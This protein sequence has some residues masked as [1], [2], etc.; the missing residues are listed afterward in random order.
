[1]TIRRRL[2]LILVGLVLMALPPSAKAQSGSW[3]YVWHTHPPSGSPGDGWAPVEVILTPSGCSGCD[4]GGSWAP[5][6]AQGLMERPADRVTVGH[7]A[8]GDR[9]PAWDP[10]DVCPPGTDLAGELTAGTWYHNAN[11]DIECVTGGC[12]YDYAHMTAYCE[13]HCHWGGMLNDGWVFIEDDDCCPSGTC[14]PPDP[15]ACPPE[16]WRYSDISAG[17]WRTAPSFPVVIGQDPSNLGVDLLFDLTLPPAT[18]TW[19]EEVVECQPTPEPLPGETPEPP[20][21]VTSCEEHQLSVRDT[22]NGAEATL[23]LQEASRRWIEN[24]LALRYPHAAVRQPH[25][26]DSA[27]LHAC[28]YA[29]NTH[30][31]T[32]LVHL[33]PE[34]PGYYDLSAG[35]TADLGGGRSFSFSGA[36]VLIYLKDTTLV[37]DN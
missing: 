20:V 21:C 6:T 9:S 13:V 26:R 35:A 31:C 22:I 8:P 17:N 33:E 28:Y 10:R 27:T 7:G 12:D 34:D 30:H 36:D 16:S 1:M 19:Y 18:R 29:G 24:E 3:Y 4:C 5:N 15:G 25:L 32:A 14:H 2:V 23:D 37:P 11:F